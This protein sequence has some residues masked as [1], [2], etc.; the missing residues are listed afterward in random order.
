MVTLHYAYH[1]LV[2]THVHV[3]AL[4]VDCG[5]Y[6]VVC[7]ANKVKVSG[8]KEKQLVYRKHTMY[9]GG[10]KETPYERMMERKPWEV[11][12]QRTGISFSFLLASQIIRHA[13]SGMLPKN[14]MRERRLERL[15]IFVGPRPTGIYNANVI[16]RWEDG[17][18][19]APKEKQ[20][21]EWEKGLIPE[22]KRAQKAKERERERRQAAVRARAGEFN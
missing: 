14:K 3:C 1:D 4:T 10:L 18:L 9:P 6:V 13:V 12:I 5:D 17:T 11:C 8:L 20:V 7:N 22:I 2:K 16:K 21:R 15:K 19:K